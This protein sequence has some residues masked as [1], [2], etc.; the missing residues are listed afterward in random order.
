[1]ELWVYMKS[2]KDVIIS[3]PLSQVFGRTFV[4]HSPAFGVIMSTFAV[5]HAVKRFQEFDFHGYDA[6]CR[7]ATAVHADALE[8]H[9]VFDAVFVPVI[10]LAH[11]PVG[12]GGVH[13]YHAGFILARVRTGFIMDGVHAT[14]Q[15]RSVSL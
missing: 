12:H 15:Q 1:V 2:I 5:D 8:L 3:L 9:P 7:S 11:E 6:V 4:V 14:V 13:N 10:A